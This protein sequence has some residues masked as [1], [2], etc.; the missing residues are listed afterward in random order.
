MQAFRGTAVWILDPTSALPSMFS[1]WHQRKMTQYHSL[2]DNEA[3]QVLLLSLCPLCWHSHE[4]AD[5]ENEA[6]HQCKPQFSQVQGMMQ[7]CRK[8]QYMY[9]W[10]KY[11]SWCH[12]D[13]S[14]PNLNSVKSLWCQPLHLNEETTWFFGP[15]YN[16]MSL[17]LT[18]SVPSVAMTTLPSSLMNFRF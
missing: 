3:S 9:Q 16:L 1:Y 13:S 4:L 12:C 5:D 17:N 11:W 6:Q 7:R 2:W 8:H 18:M 15:H 10:E 14:W